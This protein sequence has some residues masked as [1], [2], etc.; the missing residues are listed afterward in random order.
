MLKIN[1]AS[2]TRQKTLEKSVM[3]DPSG[4]LSTAGTQD[5]THVP[6]HA[7]ESRET[8]TASSDFP[9][10]LD[11]SVPLETTLGQSSFSMGAPQCMSW[12]SG[13]K[14]AAGWENHHQGLTQTVPALRLSRDCLSPALLILHE[15]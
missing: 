5:H 15:H 4:L 1:K 10:Y 11:F 14:G 13:D 7:A 9:D 6:Q 2:F 12:H 3:L 8:L